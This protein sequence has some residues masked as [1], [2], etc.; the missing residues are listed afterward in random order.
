MSVACSTSHHTARVLHGTCSP[1]PSTTHTLIHTHSRA[2]MLFWSASGVALARRVG[3]VA[4]DAESQC[5]V[6]VSGA[7]EKVPSAVCVLHVP[8]RVPC[9]CCTCHGEYDARGS[10]GGDTNKPHVRGLRGGSDATERTAQVFQ[11]ALREGKAR[12]QANKGR[13]LDLSMC[14]FDWHRTRPLPRSRASPAQSRPPEPATRRR[15]C[16]DARTRR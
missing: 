16:C 5:A 8:P 9:L 7:A 11:Q 15:C 14:N 10:V 3:S 2:L 6:G 12:L 13:T 4:R 1:R